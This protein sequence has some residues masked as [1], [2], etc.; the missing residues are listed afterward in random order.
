M[1]VKGTPSSWRYALFY[2]SLILLNFTRI[3][4]G[5]FIDIRANIRLTFVSGHPGPLFTKTASFHGHS[6]P[7]YK[8]NKV[9]QQFQGYKMESLYQ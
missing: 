4:H 2:F 6:D 1:L 9:W 3:N 7:H 5:Y 8:H